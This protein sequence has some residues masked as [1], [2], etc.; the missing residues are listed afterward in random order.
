MLAKP[1]SLVVLLQV[2]NQPLSL[3]KNVIYFISLCAK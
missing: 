1:Q 3:K 2:L